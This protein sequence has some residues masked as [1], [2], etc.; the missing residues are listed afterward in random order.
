MVPRERIQKLITLPEGMVAHFHSLEGRER[1]SWFCC[2]D[3]AERRA[4]SGGG[5]AHILAQAYAASGSESSFTDWLSA[6]KRM[7]IHSG[8]ESRRLPAYA[9]CGKSL[10]P[11]P[12]FR[13]SKG[14]YLDQKLLDFQAGYYER[15]LGNAPGSYCTLIGSGDVMFISSD[16][17][18][19][20]PEADVLV[21][22]IWVEDEV[23]SHHGVFFSPRQHP[24]ELAFVRQKPSLQELR[25][26]SLTHFYLMDSGIVLM[27][28]GATLKL[29]EK[30]GWITGE[31]RFMEGIPG[32]YDLYG[33][34]LTSFGTGSESPDP[35]LADL[36]VKLV[37]LHHG[38]FYHFGSNSDLI[39]ST[40]KL[41]NRVTDQRLTFTRETDHHPSIF[42]QNARVRVLFTDKNH[43]IWIENSCIP[44][45]WKLN[46]HHILTGI[47]END[48]TLEVDSQHCIDVVPLPDDRFATRVYGF[49]DRFGRGPGLGETWMGRTF[50][51]WLE[52][53]SLTPEAA[54]LDPSASLFDM[55]L[56]PVTG[57]E[58]IPLMI[59]FMAGGE[60]N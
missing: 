39:R 12:V 27:N 40:L 16:R 50:T 59:R 21:F 46:D 23:A 49:S 30:S 32:L 34:M 56:F 54:G 26:F 10:L 22:G 3:P 29:M 18:R 35:G 41:Q 51:Q 5:A 17:F 8:G 43:H 36:R 57:K 13:W 52:E 9:P 28:A 2:S 58:E 25:E 11:V 4:G 24:G 7:V 19:D 60:G 47:P 20:L 31:E 15:I 55:P 1:V 33:E 44:S 48:W 6:G 45:S 42:Q 14:Q 38:E 37:P 53:R